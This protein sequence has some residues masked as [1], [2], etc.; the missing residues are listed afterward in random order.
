MVSAADFPQKLRVLIADDDAATRHDVYLAL[1][2]SGFEVC[3]EASNAV[4]A[5]QRALETKPDICLLEVR[6]PGCGVA[7]AWEIAARLP[8]TKVVMLTVS[9][10]D[11]DLFRALRAGA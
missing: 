1:E 9:D 2:K 8:T 10:E 4:E 5:I 6:M 11:G 3:A 7:A